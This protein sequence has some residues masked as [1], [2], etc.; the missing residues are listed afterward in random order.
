MEK[1]QRIRDLREDADLTQQ[2]VGKA[3]NVP[4]RTYAYYESGQRMDFLK[5]ATVRE[6]VKWL[7]DKSLD[8]F[9]V[10][11]NKADKDYSPTTMYNDYSV[12]ESLSTGRARAPRRR[13][14]LPASGIFTTGSVAP[15]C[16]CSSGSSRRTTSRAVPRLIPI[17]ARQAM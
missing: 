4:Q 2:Q 16:C 9:F 5:P 13:I 12:S 11:L 1:Y 6:G 15:E 14:L 17:S 8:V 3:I 10:T 7:P